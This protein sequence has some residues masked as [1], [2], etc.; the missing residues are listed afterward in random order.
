[1][2]RSV[3]EKIKQGI[4]FEAKQMREINKAIPVNGTRI[5]ISA[6]NRRIEAVYYKAETKCAIIS[7][8]AWRRFSFWRVCTG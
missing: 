3:L 2:E 1:M 4:I 8:Y 7:L 5:Q 6:N